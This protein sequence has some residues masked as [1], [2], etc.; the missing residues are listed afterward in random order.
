[1]GMIEKAAPQDVP[2]IKTPVGG[3]T[4]AP[5]EPHGKFVKER[6]HICKEFGMYYSSIPV[7]QTFRHTN[8]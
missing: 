8:T 7:C 6:S 5:D 2:E 3:A 1:M 4:I